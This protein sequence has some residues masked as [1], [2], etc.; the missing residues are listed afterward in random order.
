MLVAPPHE[1]VQSEGDFVGMHRTPGDD[2]L[3]LDAIIG[4]R[5]DLHEFGFDDVCLPHI[6]FSMA[7]AAKAR[8]AAGPQGYGAPAPCVAARLDQEIQEIADRPGVALASCAVTRP[9]G[10]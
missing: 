5:A 2:A 1:M 9:R 3:Q 4:H 10:Y 8:L 6:P 7:H